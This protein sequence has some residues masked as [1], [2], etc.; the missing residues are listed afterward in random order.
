MKRLLVTALGL[1]FNFLSSYCQ[2]VEW[3]TEIKSY[4]SENIREGVLSNDGY[5]YL[6]GAIG[7][8]GE[9]HFGNTVSQAFPSIMPHNVCFTAKYDSLGNFIWLKLGGGPGGGFNG[10]AGI[11]GNGG[12]S[13]TVDETQNIYTAGFCSGNACFDSICLGSPANGEKN[14]LLKYDSGGN[15]KWAKRY[16]GVTNGSV[17]DVDGS[18]LRYMDGYLYNFASSFVNGPFTFYNTTINPGN[19]TAQ[20]LYLT[21]F[22]TAGNFLFVKEIAR[23]HYSNL[24]IK[25]AIPLNDNLYVTGFYMHDITVGSTN[26]QIP[27]PKA[28]SFMA[29]YSSSGDLIWFKFISSNKDMNFIMDIDLDD[30]QNI[31]ASGIYYDTL[32]VD[33]AVFINPSGSYPYSFLCKFDTAGNVIW[34]QNFYGPGYVRNSAVCHVHDTIFM[35]GYYSGYLHAGN[36][37]VSSLTGESL[38]I[39]KLDKLGNAVKAETYGEKDHVDVISMIKDAENKL[40]FIGEYLNSTV[41]GSYH[42]FADSSPGIHNYTD[43]YIFKYDPWGAPSSV[44]SENNT[45]Q[46]LKFYPNPFFNKFTTIVSTKEPVTI[47]FYDILPQKILQETFTTS[48]TINTEHQPIGMYVFELRNDKGIMATGRIIKQ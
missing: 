48:T 29:K 37:I 13:I 21:K 23:S 16:G 8:D 30:Q 9:T 22:D 11:N 43:G 38:F 36:Q 45:Q 2:S 18:C 7:A 40:Y 47:T 42:L 4:L 41:I 46:Y 12:E 5:I 24:I 15:I 35:S 33:S 6:T 14:L 20:I 17:Y 1:V 27:L 25:D 10:N 28:Q 19:N 44:F 39:L 32:I 34:N 3:L 31:L 26:Y